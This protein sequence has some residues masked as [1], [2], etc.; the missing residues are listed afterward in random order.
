M[1]TLVDRSAVNT[2]LAEAAASGQVLEVILVVHGTV[3]PVKGTHRWRIRVGTRHVLTFS[4]DSV[5]AA[6]AVSA[7]RAR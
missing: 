7:G 1:K 6:T 5:V 2:R 4:A 3:R